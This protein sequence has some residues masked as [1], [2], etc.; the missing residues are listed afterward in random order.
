VVRAVLVI[1]QHMP[2]TNVCREVEPI[3]QTNDGGSKHL[4]G[5]IKRRTSVDK[6]GTSALDRHN[7]WMRRCRRFALSCPRVLFVDPR[8]PPYGSADNAKRETVVLYCSTGH[9][10][11][12]RHCFVSW[13]HKRGH[14]AVLC[15]ALVELRQGDPNICGEHGHDP[16]GTDAAGEHL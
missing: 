10:M 16:R 3:V 12:W 8:L 5:S 2:P 7:C 11:R 14:L 4:V 9:W 6:A 1:R 15:C 13:T